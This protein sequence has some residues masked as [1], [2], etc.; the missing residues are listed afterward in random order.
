MTDLEMWSGLVGFLLP[1][2][3]ALVQQP[4]FNGPTRVLVTLAAS[5]GASAVTAALQGQLD[6][7]RWFHSV[8]VVAVATIAFYHGAWKPSGV[9]PSLE[10]GTS[11]KAPA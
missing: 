8:L 4:R 5:A 10:A 6:W 1:G 2:V 3:I 9:A 7:H 11:P